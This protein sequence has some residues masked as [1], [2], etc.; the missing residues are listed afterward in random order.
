MFDRKELKERGKSAFKAN[1]WQCVVVALI[2]AIVTGGSGAAGGRASGNS[3]GS[4]T[5]NFDW[6]VFFNPVVIGAIVVVGIGITLL[7]IFVLSLFEIGGCKFFIK[8]SKGDG[9]INDII[10]PFVSGNY[11]KMVVTLFLRDLFIVL[12]TCLFVIPGIIKTFEYYMVPY[13]MAD[14]PE[15]SRKEAFA[16]SKEMMQGNK[17]KTFVLELSFLG[18]YIL[19][20]CTCGIVF[21]LWSDPYAR[22]TKA[23]LYLELK[24]NR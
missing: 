19:G 18:W 20:I 1:Y 12:W 16:L 17:W 4:G 13:I 6:N 22:A 9:L 11:L 15:I 2:L 21:V 24:N 14:N 5:G 7:S 3:S 23:E 8:N 10:F